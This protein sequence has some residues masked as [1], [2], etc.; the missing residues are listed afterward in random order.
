[1]TDETD[2]KW[3]W[4]EGSEPERYEGPFDTRDQALANATESAR[5]SATVTVCEGRRAALDDDCFG[6]PDVIEGW[7]DQNEENQDENGELGMG[8]TPE[9]EREL[10][11]A[12]AETF[13]AWRTRHGLGR[14]WHLAE[15]RNDYVEE[16]TDGG[17][18][19]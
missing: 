16:L 4:G 7:T 15:R 3:W 1:M 12:L 6:A 14:A 8:P 10:E 9:Q 11:L 17:A 2:W 13:T 5:E 19:R 18:Q